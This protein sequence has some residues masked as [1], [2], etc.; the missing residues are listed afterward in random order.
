MRHKP[1]TVPSF[2]KTKEE[3]MLDFKP[4]VPADS[5]WLHP[6]LN[7]TENISCEFSPTCLIMWGHASIAECDGFYVP[8]VRYTEQPQYLRPIGRSDFL[9]ILPEL[10]ADSKERGIPFRMSGITAPVREVLE[11]TGLF[12]FTSNRDY[13]DYVYTVEALTTLAGSKLH[14]KRNHINR[15]I[16]AY[17]DWSTESITQDNIDECREMAEAWYWEHFANGAD[18]KAYASEQRALQLG[19]DHFDEFGM[20][21]LLLRVDGKVI[22]FSMGNQLNTTVYD[23]NFE[24]AYA[25]I[26]GAYP[27]INREFSRMVQ[28]KY[29]TIQYLDREDDTG[30]EGLR[31]AKL[32]Y[33]PALILEKFTATLADGAL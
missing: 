32:S 33:H 23:V 6:I 24:K 3:T 27:M 19:F 10:I 18:P 28:V 30:S 25:S 5:M 9:P 17:P 13:S 8:M 11:Q 12:T 7:K 21:G 31:K 22:A 29:P 14:S 16:E 15:I 26:Q 1:E 4:V 20:D 2:Y